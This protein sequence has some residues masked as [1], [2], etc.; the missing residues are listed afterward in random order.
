MPGNTL[1]EFARDAADGRLVSNIGRSQP[2]R[3]HSSEMK[4]RFEQY[5]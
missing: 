4:S 5:D 2:A 1:I 3:G